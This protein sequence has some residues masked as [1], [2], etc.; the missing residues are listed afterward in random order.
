MGIINRITK[1]TLQGEMSRT[2]LTIFSMAIAATLVVATL[3]GFTSGQDSLYHAE[4]KKTGGMQFVIR[5]VPRQKAANYGRMRQWKSPSSL[6]TWAGSLYPRLKGSRTQR[7]K[8]QNS[9]PWIKRRSRNW[10][11]R[12][13]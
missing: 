4:L 10:P 3:V 12:C 7:P 1:R 9:W 6:P 2:L 8:R 13:W 11:N 5:N